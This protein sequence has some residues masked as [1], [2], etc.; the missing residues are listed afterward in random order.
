MDLFMILNAFTLN[1]ILTMVLGW[2][3]WI[4]TCFLTVENL[5]VS[6]AKQLVPE[7]EMTR[8]CLHLWPVFLEVSTLWFIRCF[9]RCLKC[10]CC[11]LCMCVCRCVCICVCVVCL[12]VC[13]LC[14]VRL[15]SFLFSQLFAFDFL[16]R[17][18]SRCLVLWRNDLITSDSSLH[19]WFPLP[20]YISRF[21]ILS[22]MCP[23]SNKC[24]QEE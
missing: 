10:V 12:C 7:C 24:V 18:G 4:F 11:V 15:F 8:L 6:G 17:L 20:G 16:N 3:A 1:L 22:H 21:S 13:M 9:I 5:K 2:E 14:C 23:T 19:L